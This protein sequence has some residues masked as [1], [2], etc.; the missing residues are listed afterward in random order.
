MG[1]A[2]A[3]Q[4]INRYAAIFLPGSDGHDRCFAGWICGESVVK[5]TPA[6]DQASQVGEIR[7]DLG[8]Q[9]FVHG[10]RTLLFA[11]LTDGFL[12]VDLQIGDL[13][14]VLA[15]GLRGALGVSP[16]QRSNHGLV[17]LQGLRGTA[18]LFQR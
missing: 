9:A 15:H 13:I 12:R 4:L 11:A 16:A 10:A 14:D 6:A 8:S 7:V 17:S 2:A 1:L 3:G 18:V 5:L